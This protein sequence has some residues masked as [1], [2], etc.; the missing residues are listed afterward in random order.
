M[1][2]DGAIIMFGGFMGNGSAHH[3]IDALVKNNVQNLTVICNDAG[4]PQYGV[5]ILVT[6][7]QCKKV[8]ASHIGLNKEMARKMSE[9]ETEVELV[10]QG[11]L[12]EQIRSHGYGLGGFLTKT[13]VG[14]LVEKGKRLI[15]VEGETFLL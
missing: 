8:I 12:V 2:P 15:N 3:L 7:K 14:T 9:G 6:N 1:I 10:P 13:G 5:G 4:L 11:T